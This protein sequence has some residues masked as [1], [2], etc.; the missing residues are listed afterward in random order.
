MADGAIMHM[1]VS[2]ISRSD[3]RSA[4]A[5]AAYRA[6]TRLHDARTGIEHDY[7]RKRGVVETFIAAPNGCDWITD[8]QTLWDAA[9]AA[10]SRKN[11]VVA[12]EWLVALPDALDAPQRAELAR[13]LAVELV[14]RF[15]VAVD[16][17]IHAPSA[18]GDQRNH[19]AHLLTT[20]RTAGPDGL[21]DKTRVL[22]AAKTGGVEIEAMRAWW[23][24]T[25][26]DALAAAQ[27]AAR[28]DHRRKVVVAAEKRA[29]AEALEAQAADVATLNATP[30]EVG[31]VWKGLGHAARA[32]RAGGL[33]ALFS[34]EET[35]RKLKDRAQSLRNEAE[36]L[37]SPPARHHGPA[38][39]ALWRRMGP[40][41]EARSAAEKARQAEREAEA[42]RMAAEKAAEAQRAKE[43]AL[44]AA[45]AA[46]EAEEAR[47]RCARDVLP[48]IQRARHDPIIG[49]LISRQG[50]DLDRPDNEVA[51][52]PIW[53]MASP[54]DEAHPVW[55]VVEYQVGARDR[56]AARLA[57]I[58]AKTA[59][60]MA[61]AAKPKPKPSPARP[62]PTEPEP[63]PD[64]PPPRRG[65]G[66]PSGP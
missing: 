23:A 8:R 17:A 60:Q 36:R 53:L 13:A 28:I 7:G 19:H 61:A 16:V 57:R 31:G 5:A 11:S 51:R 65:W 46:R 39:T 49:L 58:E 55:L 41:W 24:G 6:G 14:T 64:P 26:N 42:A 27:S 38:L 9:E 30:G 62:V 56:R 44:R 1:S 45:T 21:G 12:R 59:A 25:V 63:D 15:G 52:D 43:A 2:T 10:E 40:V 4:V 33:S 20:T 50:I 37:A 66:G 18:E 34:V 35:V 32:I 47:E 22:D 29:E 48:L 54:E 3:G